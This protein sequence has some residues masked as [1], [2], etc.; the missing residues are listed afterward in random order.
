MDVS[1]LSQNWPHRHQKDNSL[2]ETI[3]IK[4]IHFICPSSVTSNFNHSSHCSSQDGFA[5]I[6]NIY[7]Y[8]DNTSILQ[9]LLTIYP[10]FKNIHSHPRL[11]NGPDGNYLYTELLWYATLHGQI[12]H[13]SLSAIT[14]L[15]PSL[16]K[17]CQ[18][19]HS[20]WLSRNK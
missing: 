14:T 2:K 3:L 16:S 15:S 7:T 18:I 13:E 19:R 20:I 5:T 6:H 17:K 11:I 8:N 4:K 1:Q 12:P 9:A 10:H